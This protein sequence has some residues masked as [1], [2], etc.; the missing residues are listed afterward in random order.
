MPGGDLRSRVETLLA[1]VDLDLDGDRPFDPRIHDPRF[2]A[3]VLAQGSL[4]LGEA[5]V[6]GWWDC[7]RLDEMIARLLRARLDQKVRRRPPL[8]S[9]LKARLLNLQSRARAFDNGERH[10]DL[11]NDLYAAMLDRRMIYT[12]AVWR[13]AE[14]LDTAQEH[15]LELVARKLRLERGMRVLDIGCGWG[16]TARYLAEEHGVEVVGITVSREQAALA[17]R[18]CHGLPVE[19][20]RADYRDLDERFDRI[21]SLGMIEHVG[22]RNYATYFDVVRRCLDPRGLFV[23]QTIGAARDGSGQDPWIERHI[24]PHAQLPTA[25]RLSAALDDRMVL[26]DWESLGADYDRTLMAWH[27]NFE[28]AWPSL[29]ERYGE[30]FRRTWRY[31]LLACAGSFRARA[32]QL[33]QLVLSPEGVTGGYRAPTI[34][35]LAPAIASSPSRARRV[36]VTTG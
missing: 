19:I 34:E 22:H 24:F 20:R 3:R 1:D 25:P 18:R 31:Y 16:G 4:G 15:K 7:E 32:N 10:Y 17:E 5:Y 35:D 12:G 33:W 27:A 2:F 28:R 13:H 29:R 8:R 23:L 9:L 30:R 26:E 11:G 14:D 6:D 21:L 36:M